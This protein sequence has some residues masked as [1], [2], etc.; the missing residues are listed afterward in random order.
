MVL[1]YFVELYELPE[2]FNNSKISLMPKIKY[3]VNESISYISFNPRYSNIIGL[4]TANYF[5]IL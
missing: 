4:L 1:N 3:K 2:D 5:M